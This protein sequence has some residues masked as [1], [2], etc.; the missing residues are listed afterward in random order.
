M[1]SFQEAMAQSKMNVFH[2]HIVDDQSF[3][4]ESRTFPE[5]S[6]QGSYTKQ[7]TYSQADIAEIL[8]FARQRGIRVVIEFDSP[9][10]TLSWGRAVDILTHCYT[11]DKPNGKFGPV[12]PSRSST[13]EFFKRFFAEI[14]NVF[15]DRYVH[16]GGDEVGF[17][18]W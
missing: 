11:L 12:D 1:I 10:H 5:L 3:P 14:A 7:D 6:D 9:G 4:Y 15:P 18:C 13:F 8:E 16:L 2:F 17:D